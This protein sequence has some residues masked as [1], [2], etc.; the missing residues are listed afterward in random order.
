MKLDLRDDGDYVNGRIYITYK[1]VSTHVRSYDAYLD[2]SSDVIYTATPY[3]NREYGDYDIHVHLDMQAVGYAFLERKILRESTPY[4]SVPDVYFDVVDLGVDCDEESRNV[5]ILLLY[6]IGEYARIKGAGLVTFRREKEKYTYFYSILARFPGITLDGDVYYM[7]INNRS[8]K[9][10]QEA[11]VPRESES[12]SEKDLRILDSLGFSDIETR[13]T[14]TLEKAALKIEVDRK[15]GEIF[16]TGTVVGPRQFIYDEKCATTLALIID[17][18]KSEGRANAIIAKEY[19]RRGRAYTLDLFLNGCEWVIQK[20]TDPFNPEITHADIVRV[21]EFTSVQ[22]LR[23]ATY[24]YDAVTADTR[25]TTSVYS[26]EHLNRLAIER[27]LQIFGE[28]KSCAPILAVAFEIGGSRFAF[29]TSDKRLY[30]ITSDKKRIPLERSSTMFL[31]KVRRLRLCE[32]CEELG[33]G[34]DVLF[35][36]GIQYE[37]GVKHISVARG[38]V[39]KILPYILDLIDY[40]VR[41]D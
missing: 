25:L 12:I 13:P 31:E 2:A 20:S 40:A 4:A 16:Y 18:A 26:V 28:P 35:R 36:L 15:S 37:D 8:G 14:L 22:L 7:P 34:G 27:R 19:V 29:S 21:L 5:A 10:H 1:N 41:S 9:A 39:P 38:G 23:T 32:M 33:C 3:R 6:Y 11:L 30:L 17:V 24:K